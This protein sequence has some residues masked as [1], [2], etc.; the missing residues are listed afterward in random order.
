MKKNRRILL[1][2]LLLTCLFG[3][4]LVSIYFYFNDTN[5]KEKTVKISVIVY[6]NNSDRWA[7]LKKGIDQGADDYKA[8]VNFVTMTEE[9]NVKEQKMLISR[10]IEN[11]AKGIILAA[12]DSKAMAQVVKDYSLVVPIVMVETNVENMENNVYISADNYSMGLNIGRS[13][14]LNSSETRTVAVFMNNLQRNSVA[15]R[16]EGLMDSL[17]YTE[18]TIQPWE[19][20]EEDTDSFLFLQEMLNNN[21][22]DVIV[23]LDD[24]SLEKVVDTVVLSESKVEIYGIGSSNKIVHY[25]DYGVINSIVFQNEFNMGY[26]SMQEVVGDIN[27]RQNIHDVD[28]EFRTVNKETMYLP[29]NQR[30]VFPIVQ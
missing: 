12:A 6:S 15:Q 3:L 21:P 7:T 27:G 28:I 5:R 10:E 17:E 30:L 25:L 11:G 1:I 4:F 20:K 26:L 23:A 29:K 24:E 22:V 9:N 16:Y 8:E 18:Y 2:I 19:K 13:V 14:C